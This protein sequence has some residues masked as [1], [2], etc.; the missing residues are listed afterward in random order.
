MLCPAIRLPQN[1]PSNNLPGFETT[2]NRL[3]AAVLH[4]ATMYKAVVVADTP[5]SNASRCIG[6]GR[7]SMGKLILYTHFKADRIFEII[8]DKDDWDGV[9]SHVVNLRG[10]VVDLMKSSKTRQ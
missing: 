3:M 4:P 7:F 6:G 5:E 1:L 10:H 2:I 8:G 9:R